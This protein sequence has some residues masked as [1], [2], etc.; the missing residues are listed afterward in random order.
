MGMLKVVFVSLTLTVNCICNAEFIECSICH[1]DFD[2]GIKDS[3]TNECAKCSNLIKAIQEWRHYC[4]ACQK[5][6]VLDFCPE[7]S[8]LLKLTESN[9][10]H[11]EDCETN[12]KIYNICL[13]CIEKLLIKKRK[14]W[15]TGCDQN[16]EPRGCL[17]YQTFLCSIHNAALRN[18]VLERKQ[19][20]P[21]CKN[22][23]LLDLCSVCLVAINANHCDNCKWGNKKYSPYVPCLACL[24]KN[25]L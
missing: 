23:C 5:L 1:N 8:I 6:I 4:P 12:H 24:E 21:K 20:C 25:K 7:C 16:I 9:D 10:E 18:A 22:R 13:G 19:K 3:S 17:G 14:C 2:S 11:I 15:Y